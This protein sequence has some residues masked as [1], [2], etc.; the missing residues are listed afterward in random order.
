[1]IALATTAFAW[2]VFTVVLVGFLVYAAL[3]QRAARKELGS[4]IELAPNRKPYYTTRSWRASA[5]SS[6]S[7]S[8]CCCSS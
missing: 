6:C 1:M 5:S 8:A 7:S 4:E 3:N 2:I